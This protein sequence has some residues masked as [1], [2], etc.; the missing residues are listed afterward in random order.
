MDACTLCLKPERQYDDHYRYK[1]PPLEVVADSRTKQRKTHLPNVASVSKNVFRPEA[2]VVKYCALANSTD[3]GNSSSSGAV[4]YL[5]GHHDAEALQQLMFAFIREY[6]L[7]KCG[8]PETLLYVDG[9]KKNKV[10]RLQCHS[11]GRTGRSAGQDAKMLNLFSAQPMPPELLPMGGLDAASCGGVEGLVQTAA[12]TA[13][14]PLDVTDGT[15]TAADDA[16]AYEHGERASSLRPAPHPSRTSTAGPKHVTWDEA[17][18]AEHRAC[19]GVLYGTQRIEETITPFLYYSESVSRGEGMM[20]EFVP[21]SGIAK[22]SIEALQERL[23]VL[24]FAQSAGE[25]LHLQPSAASGAGRPLPPAPWLL[26]QSRAAADECFYY[27]PTT[28]EATWTLPAA[29]TASD[30]KGGNA[31]P[32]AEHDAKAVAPEESCGGGAASSHDDEDEDEVPLPTSKLAAAADCAADF[33][34]RRRV[35]SAAASRS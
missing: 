4:A 19:A 1:M 5:T 28:R 30:S 27:N 31:A 32:S 20:G 34:H 22:V 26:L 14:S 25:D 17:T 10:A 23:G 3:S 33:A 18:I 29:D 16:R 11:C 12:V 15:S 21:G 13:S 2:W 8:S 24:A 7:C 9:K 35:A 6:V